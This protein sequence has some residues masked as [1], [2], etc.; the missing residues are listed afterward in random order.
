[1]HQ[2]ALKCMVLSW[3]AT[4]RSKL[5]NTRKVHDAPRSLE[6]HEFER[7]RQLLLGRRLSAQKEAKSEWGSSADRPPDE[8]DV[9]SNETQTAFDSRLQDRA[10]AL[11][12]K[13]DKAL[14][15]IDSGEYDE[16][17]SCGDPIGPGRLQARPEATLCIECKEEEEILERG[18]VKSGFRDVSDVPD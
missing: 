5:S 17:E 8:S 15:R 18:Y 13:I 9:A 16:C 14:R 2:S 7:F 10:S 11:L 1:M 6:P 12:V 4:R 3:F